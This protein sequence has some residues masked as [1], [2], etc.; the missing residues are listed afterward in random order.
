[1][2]FKIILLIPSVILSLN[3]FGLGG[4]GFLGGGFNTEPPEKRQE[5]GYSRVGFVQTQK[6]Q[7]LTPTTNYLASVGGTSHVGG[8]GGFHTQPAEKD[9]EDGYSRVGYIQTQKGQVL[10]PTTNY[11][12]SAGGTGAAGGGGGFHTQPTEKDQEDGYSRVG[13]IQTQKRQVL[14]K[15]NSLA[16]AG[17]GGIA[18]GGGLHTQ[19]PEQ[20]QEDG[21]SRVQFVERHQGEMTFILKRDGVEHIFSLRPEE[22]EPEMMKLI[23]K[24]EQNRREPVLVEI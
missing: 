1:M 19:P 22:I 9:Q 24:S 18:G 7:V 5:D 6:G 16:T 12:A 2:N 4:S 14:P 20:D 23:L 17:N 8:G 10:I 11:L 3:A 21:Y 13:F 15:V